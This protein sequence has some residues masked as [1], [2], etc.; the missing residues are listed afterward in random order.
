MRVFWRLFLL[1]LLGAVFLWL[2]RAW[3]FRSVVHY[4]IVGERGE[5]R[6]IPVSTFGSMDLDLAIDAALDTTAVRLH[7]STGAV[8]NDP[9]KL[10]QGSP[11]NCIGYAAL[12]ASLLKGQLETAGL[13]D[14]YMVEA[15]IGKLYMGDQDL[16]ALFTSPFWKDHDVVRIRETASGMELLLDPTLYD[17]VGI[18][19][20]SGRSE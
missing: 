7:F 14:R 10:G 12:C 9:R 15:V 16:H 8:S 1:L 3:T 6:P 11:A 13:G 2:T 5:V 4:R 18:G 20:V 17:A 19:R